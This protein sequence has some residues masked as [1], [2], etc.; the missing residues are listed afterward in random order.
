MKKKLLALVLTLAMALSLA[1]C[2]GGD[3]PA[4]SG[5]NDAPPAETQEPAD[6]A[7]VDSGASGETYKVGICQLAPHPAL[8]AA[9]QG[10]TEAL[11]ALLPGQVEIDPQ[12]AA[13][14]TP[15]SSTASSPEAWT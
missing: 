2:G 9:T 3:A 4:D 7:P 12:N 6:A 1:A 10:F 13:G 8:D 5:T 15:P 11:E 14:D